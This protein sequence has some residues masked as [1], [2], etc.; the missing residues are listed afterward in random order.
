MI[1][2]A[3]PTQKKKD[4]NDLKA[5]ADAIGGH[6]EGPAAAGGDAKNSDMG[7]PRKPGGKARKPGERLT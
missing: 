2:K 7:G 1:K 5:I 4:R 3:A 6:F